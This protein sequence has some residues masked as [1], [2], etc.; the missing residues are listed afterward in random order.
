MVGAIIARFQV[1]QLHEGHLHLIRTAMK[2]CPE[3]VFLLGVA[4]KS[5]AAN[6][7]PFPFRREMILER[8]PGVTV[9]PLFDRKTNEEWSRD[10]DNILSEYGDVTIFHS[11]ASFKDS[12]SG[13]LPLQEVEEVPEVSGTTVRKSITPEY[14][15]PSFRAGII[16][17]LTTLTNDK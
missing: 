15:N 14:R 13:R 12:Y 11:R 9:I 8:F 1:Q 6:P 17:A 2:Q 10:V 3:V 16:Y 4:F 5:S 7:L